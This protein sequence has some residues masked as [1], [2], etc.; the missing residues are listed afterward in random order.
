MPTPQQDE[1]QEEFIARCIPAV[2][3]E[4]TA[5]DQEQAAAICYSYWR[6]A[7]SDKTVT[8]KA[9]EGGGYHVEGYGV[10]WDGED[11]EGQHF[12]K[13]TDF[14]FDRLTKTPP[15]LYEHGYDDTLKTTV[16][17]KVTTITPDEKGLW[18]EAQLE[19]SAKY[20]EY[21][22][23]ILELA[24]NKKLGF[25]SGAAGHLCEFSGDYKEI[26]AWPIVEFSLT[27]T[28]AE[29]RTL[30]VAALRSLGDSDPAI[31]ALVPEDASASAKGASRGEEQGDIDDTTKT[32]KETE[33]GDNE[34]KAVAMPD[35]EELLKRV[36]QETATAIMKGLE[37]EE[38]KE[39]GAF[40]LEDAEGTHSLGDYLLAVRRKDTK[41]LVEE[42]H[43]QKAT[44]DLLEE[45]GVSGGYLVPAE[46]SADFINIAAEMSVVR[47]R[48]RIQPM[49]SRSLAIPALDQDEQ[50]ADGDKIKWFG[51]V[52]SYWTEEG[53]TKTETEPSFR[54]IELV[55]HKLAGYTQASDE[56]L[57]DS[58]IGLEALLR[59]LFGQAIAWREDYAYLRGDG[60][61][62]P[63]GI[64][65]SGALLTQDRATANRIIY[66]D[67]AR[68]MDLFLPEGDG[69]WIVS[70]TARSEL[71]R[72]EDSAGNL[73]WQQ[74]ARV[75]EPPTMLGMPVVFSSKMPALGTTGDVL[76][77]DLNYYVIGD[78]QATSIQ[79]SAEYAFI[80]DLTTWRFV[81]RVDGQPL[82]AAPI[83]IDNTNQVSPFVALHADTTT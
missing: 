19:R 34:A 67:V 21:I 30:G 60:V 23:D 9:L 41:R 43:A 38:P 32:D 47:P 44:K 75:G 40:R 61:G 50:P 49:R 11:L 83:Y 1:T 74:N 52:I 55:A 14:W 58:A 56:L 48:A 76:L 4:G 69:T 54:Q 68:M 22:E 7:M 3:D 57:A 10:V 64:L 80:D 45:S 15:L 59:T 37:K 78:R 33:M 62:K 77:A 73:V 36:S 28:P 13:D 27:V 29:P 63:L 79:S 53:V 5:E 35:I 42:Y 31:K 26:R 51:G 17:G 39:K 71:L 18:L 70:S 81:H 6:E 66:R 16:L 25:S 2:L 65:N 46:F 8:I 12:S 20:E 82:L 24:D 72:L